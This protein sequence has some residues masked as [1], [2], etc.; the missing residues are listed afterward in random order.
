[1]KRKCFALTH[2]PGILISALQPLFFLKKTGILLILNVCANPKLWTFNPRS[3]KIHD[4]LKQ[5]KRKAFAL[6]HLLGISILASWVAFLDKITSILL[7]LVVSTNL[8]AWTFNPQ[9]IFLDVRLKQT[10]TKCFA[11][12]HRLGISI[13]AF[14]IFMLIKISRISLF[15]VVSTNLGAWTFSPHHIFLHVRLKQSKRK[16]FALANRLGISNLASWIFLLTKISRISLFFVVSTNLEAWT[17][18]PQH[19][20]LDVRLKRNLFF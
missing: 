10:K 19:I 18:N 6:A 8:E 5:T 3:Q 20:F 2:Q 13:L 4:Q 12:A 16:A 7:F 14:W 1:M 17:F 15:L 11:L 9:H